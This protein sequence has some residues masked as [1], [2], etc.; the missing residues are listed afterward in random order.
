[1]MNQSSIDRGFFRSMFFRTYRVRPA[2]LETPF[3]ALYLLLGHGSA[4]LTWSQYLKMCLGMSTS[5]PLPRLHVADPQEPGCR[6]R[7]QAGR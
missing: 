5:G 2:C 6:D 3:Q 1:M 4:E 7:M